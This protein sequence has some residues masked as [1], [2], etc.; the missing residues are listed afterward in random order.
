LSRNGV[1]VTMKTTASP[2]V[3]IGETRTTIN[4]PLTKTKLKSN[5]INLF[6]LNNQQ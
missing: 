5:Q 2:I 4:V 1:W 3:A 6:Y